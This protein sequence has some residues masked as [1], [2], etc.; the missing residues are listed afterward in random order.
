MTYLLALILLAQTQS[1]QL[2]A[3]TLIT[4]TATAYYRDDYGSIH[5]AEAKSCYSVIRSDV[6]RD[7][8]V[9]VCGR[10]DRLANGMK[11]RVIIY[12]QPHDGLQISDGS[13]LIGN[14]VVA[15]GSP[16]FCIAN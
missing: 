1:P 15:K 11:V 4:Q 8:P 5:A 7:R 12:G 10:G 14:T 3:G 13:V 9:Y 2:P 6:W 16:I